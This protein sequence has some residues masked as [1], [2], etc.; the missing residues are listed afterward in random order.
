MFGSLKT[1]IFKLAPQILEHATVRHNICPLILMLIK[2]SKIRQQV[3]ENHNMFII[4]LFYTVRR[5][6][7]IEVQ[8]VNSTAIMLL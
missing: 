1:F 4:L 5:K 8:S 3:N 6:M 2:W 7:F